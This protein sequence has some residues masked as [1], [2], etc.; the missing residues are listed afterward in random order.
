MTP[1]TTITQ[2]RLIK[3]TLLPPVTG[4]QGAQTTVV[5]LARV[6]EYICTRTCN[7]R[8]VPVTRPVTQ[9]TVAAF[10]A[11]RSSS[12]PHADAT[13]H[14]RACYEYMYVEHKRSTLA[15]ASS[16]FRG[17]RPS[18]VRGTHGKSTCLCRRATT[19]TAHRDQPPRE[20]RTPA[21]T[22]RLRA[23]GCA[24]WSRL[25]LARPFAAP[26]QP[27]GFSVP[28]EPRTQPQTHAP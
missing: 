5:M 6:L 28:V 1:Q 25:H 18:V 13:H 22:I 26:P 21:V 23:V 8:V 24:R 7:Y 9:I 14:D 12:L 16:P 27:R 15:S 10:A 3:R 4:R 19:P 20:S 17:H 11:V 2:Q